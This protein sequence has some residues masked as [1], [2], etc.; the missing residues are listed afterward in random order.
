[1]YL[2][3]IG[4]NSEILHKCVRD[5]FFSCIETSTDGK[6]G[7]IRVPGHVT[8]LTVPS[9]TAIRAPSALGCYLAQNQNWRVLTSEEFYRRGYDMPDPYALLRELAELKGVDIPPEA[10][11]SP[12]ESEEEEEEAEEAEEVVEADENPEPETEPES[13]EEKEEEEDGFRCLV[14]G[15]SKVCTSPRGLEMHRRAVHGVRGT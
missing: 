14:A 15:C 8:R 11:D 4:E 9:G 1:M 6:L 12:P 10:L 7:Y 13:E 3:A 2:L 5:P